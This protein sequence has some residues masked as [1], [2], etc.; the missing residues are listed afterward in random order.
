[1]SVNDAS[2]LRRLLKKKKRQLIHMG[3]GV[4]SLAS[5]GDFSA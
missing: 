4:L 2:A 5:Y 3:S 1:M